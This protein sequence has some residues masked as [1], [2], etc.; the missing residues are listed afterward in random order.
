MWTIKE[1]AV[2]RGVAVLQL[3]KGEKS[4]RRGSERAVNLIWARVAWQK[5][6]GAGRVLVSA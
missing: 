4:L 6:P 3:N 5:M 1:V 2:M